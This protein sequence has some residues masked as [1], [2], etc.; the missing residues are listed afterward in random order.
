MKIIR[1]FLAAAITLSLVAGFGGVQMKKSVFVEAKEKKIKIKAASDFTLKL[2][3]NWKNGYVMKKSKKIKHGSYVAFY[4]KKCHRQT[5]AGWLFTIMRYKDDSYTDM[6]SYELVGKWNGYSYVAL[7]PT[8]VQ[9]DGAAKSAKKQYNKLNVGALK[10]AASIQ[11]I[12]KKM[13]KGTYHVD[14]FSLMIPKSWKKNYTVERSKTKKKKDSYV[15]FYSKKCHKQTKA[16]WL[17][18]IGRYTDESYTDLPAYE[19]VGKWKGVNYVAIFP[20]DVQSEGAT[21]AAVKQYQKL[22]KSA[23]KVARSIMP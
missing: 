23:E 21:K 6:P 22:S 1:S 9:T 12:K 5:K 20:T 17:F 16:G 7:F 3:S 15:A 8:D 10:A 13:K 19:L 14:D 4:S 18:S 2:P 11:P